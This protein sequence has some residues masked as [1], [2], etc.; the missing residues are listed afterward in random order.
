MFLGPMLRDDFVRPLEREVA[1]M[2]TPRNPRLTATGLDD[3]NTMKAIKKQAS[4]MSVNVIFIFLSDDGIPIIAVLGLDLL[5]DT[6][7]FINY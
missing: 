4:E 7:D 1:K 3:L 5:T 2:T 6:P